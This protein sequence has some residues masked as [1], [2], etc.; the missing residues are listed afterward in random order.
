VCLC[1]CKPK[2]QRSYGHCQ[3]LGR[4]ERFYLVTKSKSVLVLIFLFQTSNLQNC[5]RIIFYFLSHLVCGTLLLKSWEAD[6]NINNGL[7]RN[8]LKWQIDPQRLWD[9]IK[10]SDVLIILWDKQKWLAQQKYQ[11]K[12]IQTSCK[13][14]EKQKFN[15]SRSSATS[16][17]IYSKTRRGT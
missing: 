2:I 8:K 3:T 10:K 7:K 16:N 15:D 14:G 11:K 6:I 4:K 13:L 5:K 17:F 12:L 1:S 9:N